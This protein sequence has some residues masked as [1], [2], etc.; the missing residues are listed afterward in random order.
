MTSKTY[1]FVH[2]NLI[3]MDEERLLL[4]QTFI[5]QNG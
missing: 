5:V 1:A 4:N 3:P 2:A